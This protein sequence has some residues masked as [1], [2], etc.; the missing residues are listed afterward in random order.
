MTGL[1]GN[2]WKG[3]G[4]RDHGLVTWGTPHEMKWGGAQG[5]DPLFRSNFFSFSCNFQGCPIPV[6]E[7]LE[8]PLI[9]EYVRDNIPTFCT[10]NGDVLCR[11]CLSIRTTNV[12]HSDTTVVYYGLL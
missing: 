7:T 1:G 4:T 8:R 6:W 9:M 10:S 5:G 2:P 11:L 12:H 3:P